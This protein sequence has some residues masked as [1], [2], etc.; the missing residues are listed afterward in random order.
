M[1]TLQ[2]KS[3]K[4]TDAGATKFKNLENIAKSRVA[5]LLEN[6][7]DEIKKKVASFAPDE[8]EE[9]FALSYPSIPSDNFFKS[10]GGFLFLSLRE[11]IKT[12]QINIRTYHGGDLMKAYFG[13]VA[14]LSPLIGFCWYAGQRGSSELRSTLD[15]G[16]AWKNLLER[17]EF[18]SSSF[19]VTPRDPGDLLTFFSIDAG[20]RISVESVEK[21]IPL[22]RQPYNMYGSASYFYRNTLLRRLKETLKESIAGAG[23]ITS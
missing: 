17:W 3:A 4:L 1:R 20:E 8:A 18:G 15:G 14:V 5:A 19:T 12:E 21:T 11:A 10:Q 6:S 16:A 22:Q 13:H 7:S 23:F 9:A 2:I